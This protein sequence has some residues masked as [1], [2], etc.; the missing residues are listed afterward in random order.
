MSR[1]GAA[2]FHLRQ[3]RATE[4][5]EIP[6]RLAINRAD[7]CD[8]PNQR[9]VPFRHRHNVGGVHCLHRHSVYRGGSHGTH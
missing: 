7:Q 6:S 2:V 8:A 3:I 4:A 9:V 1:P 5:N